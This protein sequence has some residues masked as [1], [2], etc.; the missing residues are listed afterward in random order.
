MPTKIRKSVGR[1]LELRG[2]TI[3]Y[4][5]ALPEPLRQHGPSTFIRS[6][7]TADLAEA[8]RLRDWLA[9]ALDVAWAEASQRIA[10]GDTQPNGP[11]GVVGEA[12]DRVDEELRDALISREERVRDALA[13]ELPAAARP[14]PVTL[15]SNPE[16]LV[17]QAFH[18][19]VSQLDGALNGRLEE[20]VSQKLASAQAER[21]QQRAASPTMGEAVADYVALFTASW[22]PSTLR[23]RRHQLAELVEAVGAEVK[24][25]E[26][27]ADALEAWRRAMGERC[28]PSTVDYAL[29]AASGFFGHCVDRDWIVR[30]PIKALRRTQK[31]TTSR[32]AAKASEERAAFTPEELRLAFDPTYIDTRKPGVPGRLSRVLAPV[33]SLLSGLRANEVGWLRAEDVVEV[34]GVTC[35]R[36]AAYDTPLHP[37]GRYDPKTAAS[38]RAVPLHPAL[39]SVVCR[40]AAKQTAAGEAMLLPGIKTAASDGSRQNTLRRPFAEW[41]KKQG[42]KRDGLVPHSLRHTFATQLQ[43]AGVE[44]EVREQLMG[45][46][47]SS[48]AARYAKGHGVKA[49]AAAVAKLDASP[50]EALLKRVEAEEL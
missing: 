47:D 7:K 42:I 29:R 50:V 17:E 35:L 37:D 40:L 13:L 11:A 38:L 33:I 20:I 25:A 41:M 1:S 36:V 22:S 14:A 5:R 4:R 15:P 31:R 34:D 23:H 28:S 2:Q 6:L 10:D 8:S 27:A 45:H 39:Q 26:V 24:L 19:L 32:R 48:M 46:S 21:A 43:A 30:N 3:F 16:E 49:L 18:Q 44:R 12:H 9:A